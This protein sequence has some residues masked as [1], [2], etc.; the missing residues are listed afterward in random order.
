MEVL[1][2]GSYSSSSIW[3]FSIMVVLRDGSSID[4]ESVFWYGSFQKWTFSDTLRNSRTRQ[5]SAVE[6]PVNVGVHNHGKD[7]M[8]RF[9]YSRIFAQCVIYRRICDPLNTTEIRSPLTRHALF[10]DRQ[11]G[12]IHVMRVAFASNVSECRLPVSDTYEK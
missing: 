10:E 11:P 9:S 6:V 4:L 3:K 7:P 8:R 2:C 5:C 1:Q 12:N